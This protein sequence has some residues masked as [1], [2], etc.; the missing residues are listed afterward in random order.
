MIQPDSY[1][2]Q[3]LLD[4]VRTA[5]AVASTTSGRDSS[6]VTLVAVSKTHEAQAIIPLIEAGQRVFGE[7]RIQ[8]A[9]A[10]W[11]TLKAQWPDLLLHFIGRL[12]SNKARQAVELF[13]AIHSVDRLSLIAPLAE[14]IKGGGR[15]IELFVQ[16]NVGDEAQKGGCAIGDLPELLSAAREAGLTIAGLMC[17]PPAGVEPAPYFALLAEHA[18]RHGLARLSMGMSDDYP[19]AIMLGATHI[20]VGTALFGGRN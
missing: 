16:V 1:S 19:T 10:K 5:I 20:R 3:T 11:P 12:Q 15:T 7:N 4:T 2:S 18:R 8:D 9:E 13:D 14:A 6:D 17:L